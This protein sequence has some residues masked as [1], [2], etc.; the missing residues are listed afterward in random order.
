M[1]CVNAAT[2]LRRSQEANENLWFEPGT[3]RRCL[4]EIGAADHG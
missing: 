3:V 1:Q 4:L 2:R